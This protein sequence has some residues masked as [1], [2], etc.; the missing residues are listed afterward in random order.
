MYMHLPE[1]KNVNNECF[2]SC[3]TDDPNNFL[4]LNEF[5]DFNEND[6]TDSVEFNEKDIYC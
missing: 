2:M 3:P 5:D 1:R 4:Y 6:D